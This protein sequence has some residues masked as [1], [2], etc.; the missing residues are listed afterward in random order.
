METF[1][2]IGMKS[3][4]EQKRLKIAYH[5]TGHAVMALWCNRAV[6]KISLKEMDSPSGSDKYL[7]HM[8]LVPSDPKEVLTVSKSVQN[9]MI[10]LG[11]FASEVLFFNDVPGIPID[12]L[13][14]AI[15]STE[16]LLSVNEFK[17]RVAMMPVPELDVSPRITN[18][19]IGAY[20]DYELHRCIKVLSEVKPAIQ[21]IAQE[22]LNKE[23]LTG[24]EVA[25][26][27]DSFIQSK[28]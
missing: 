4:V 8:T 21:I 19:L 28:R 17:E 14:R 15:K 27:L 23:E 18:P 24:D 25:A 20:I 12:D 6:Q 5:E 11:G 10:S 2:E 9:V 13:D 3:A 7:G 22:L 26:L 1:R 16:G